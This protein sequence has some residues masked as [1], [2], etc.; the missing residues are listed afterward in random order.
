MPQEQSLEQQLQGVSR[1]A[2][3]PEFIK[4]LTRIREA[5]PSKRR[6]ILRRWARP[7]VFK[8]LG[9]PLAPGIRVTT[10]YFFEDQKVE[11]KFATRLSRGTRRAGPQPA[12][13]EPQACRPAGWP[14]RVSAPAA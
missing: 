1:V 7:S 8:K 14:E 11:G 4:V 2:T 3:H 9:I 6:A 5:P 10:R 13:A 12:A